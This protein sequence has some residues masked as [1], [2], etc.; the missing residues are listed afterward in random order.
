MLYERAKPSRVNSK[1][2]GNWHN[3]DFTLI[4]PPIKRQRHLVE[5][6]TVLSPVGQMEIYQRHK[7]L[8]VP[9]L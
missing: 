8:V 4:P 3:H 5:L 9:A 2:G 6:L 1:G 7:A